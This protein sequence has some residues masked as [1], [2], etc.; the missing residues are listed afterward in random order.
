MNSTMMPMPPIHW[1]SA[2]QRNSAR[3]KASKSRSTV[4]PVVVKPDIDS[5]TASIGPMPPVIR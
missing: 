3:P 4:A 2:R 5:N 1:L